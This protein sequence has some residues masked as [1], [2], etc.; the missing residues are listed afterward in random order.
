MA[1]EKWSTN[2]RPTKCIKEKG[3][4]GK[5]GKNKKLFVHQGRWTPALLQI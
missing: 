1:S 2:I 4:E 5:K 3:R